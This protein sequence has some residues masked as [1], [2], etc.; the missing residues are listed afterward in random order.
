MNREIFK[1]KNTQKR[2]G[3]YKEQAKDTTLPKT[4]SLL[5]IILK[6]N[7]CLYK[8]AYKQVKQL[9]I[10]PLQKAKTISK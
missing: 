3:S 7:N 4:K 8:Q 2:E 6:Q 9:N 10:V 5:L 1:K